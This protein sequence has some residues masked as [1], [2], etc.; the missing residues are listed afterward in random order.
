MST[1]PS[2]ILHPPTALVCALMRELGEHGGHLATAELA[3]AV[4]AH[5]DTVRRALQELASQGWVDQ[6]KARD[7]SDRWR[8]GPELPRIGLAHLAL[9]TA[10]QDA[11]RD[12]FNAATVRHQWTTTP[13]GQP[14]W[15]P[16][17]PS[18]P[19]ETP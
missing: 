11:L 8:I 9:L 12:R 5:R 6:S 19:E 13:D 15:R 14:R 17:Q 1:P 3:D 16:A 10:E 7:G 4:G 18:T 2:N